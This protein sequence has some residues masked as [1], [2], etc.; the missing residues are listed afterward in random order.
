MTMI[1]RRLKHREKSI[2]AHAERSPKALEK[3]RTKQKD[4]GLPVKSLQSLLKDLATIVKQHTGPK[5][6]GAIPSS[7][8]TFQPHYSKK[9]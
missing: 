5:M 1:M 3:A 4:E 8:I 2:V 7:K 6:N 9:L